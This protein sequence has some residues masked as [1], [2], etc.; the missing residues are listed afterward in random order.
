MSILKALIAPEEM[1]LQC[2]A[3]TA[4]GGTTVTPRSENER[5][6]SPNDGA[7]CRRCGVRTRA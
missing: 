3:D 2:Q 5:V 6:L 4:D 1:C 7:L